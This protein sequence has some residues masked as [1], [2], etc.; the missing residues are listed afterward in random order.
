M[1]DKLIL[2]FGLE[3]VWTVSFGPHV[4]MHGASQA[5]S[6]C[7]TRAPRTSVLKEPSGSC[8]VSC[9]LTS[10]IPVL[11][12]IVLA[13]EITK[14]GPHSERGIKLHLSMGGLSKNLQPS[15]I[16]HRAKVLFHHLEMGNF[17]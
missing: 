4:T 9:N 5:F 14:A 6:Y 7:V 16:C 3:F 1:T 13:K 11:C 10:E 15:L 17:P 2:A 12:H 8:K